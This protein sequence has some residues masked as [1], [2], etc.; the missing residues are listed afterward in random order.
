MKKVKITLLLMVVAITA[1]FA[2]IPFKANIQ[3]NIKKAELLKLKQ[4]RLKPIVN[5]NKGGSKSTPTSTYYIDYSA[6][7]DNFT[8]N[9]GEYVWQFKSVPASNDTLMS[10]A[11]MALYYSH[12]ASAS[13]DSIIVFSDYAN[14]STSTQ[15]FSYPTS[16][17][18]DSIFFF[19][20]HVNHSGLKDSISYDIVPLNSTNGVPTLTSPLHSGYKNTT[21]TLSPGGHWLGTNAT[22]TISFG[23]GYT[24]NQKTGI[25]M[26]YYPGNPSDTFST[27]VAYVD[28]GSGNAA[29]F[30]AL[31]FSFYS[32]YPFIT[33]L[34]RNTGITSGGNPSALEDWTTAGQVTFTEPLSASFTYNPTAPHAASSVSFSATSNGSAA[35]YAWN[36]GDGTSNGTGVNT[37]HTFASAGTYTVTLT[38]TDG[39][40][41]SVS[42]SITVLAP[43]GVSE[44]HNQ[45]FTGKL[46][47]NPAKAGAEMI[48]PVDLNSTSNIATVKVFNA[49][50]QTVAE[51]TQTVANQVTFTT[52]G[53]K[54]G[55]YFYSVEIGGQ[56]ANGKFT[57]VE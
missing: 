12:P 49:L 3:G 28:D 36:W 39:T 1:T 50:G 52:A 48:L 40:N 47:P 43:L 5:N 41:V 24:T 31:P 44:I 11:A 9:T 17:T 42:K 46:Y 32:Y 4:S 19:S 37:A 26:N 29:Q 51:S 10:K 57:V 2:Q 23:P 54:S 7:A 20:T 18:I 45:F 30:S 15:Y 6:L 34:A 56:K 33:N 38:A 22:A 53:L 25:A 13:P 35:T 27:L 8:S 55:I 14:V 21:T 16:I